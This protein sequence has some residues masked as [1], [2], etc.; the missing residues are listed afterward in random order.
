[1]DEMTILGLSLIVV[2]VPGLLL[3]SRAAFSRGTKK[4]VSR[5]PSGPVMRSLK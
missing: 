4:S 3:A 1:M 2:A 5:M